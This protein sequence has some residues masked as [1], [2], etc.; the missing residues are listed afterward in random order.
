MERRY[1]TSSERQV[2]LAYQKG[3]IENSEASKHMLGFKI[4]NKRLNITVVHLFVH[5]GEHKKSDFLFVRGDDKRI[6]CHD[7]NDI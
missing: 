4:T 2:A 1:K 5:K 6:I 7:R 3:Q